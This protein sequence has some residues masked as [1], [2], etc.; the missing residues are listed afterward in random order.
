MASIYDY[1]N[2]RSYLRDHLDELKT[3]K[4]GLTQ[5]AIQM[6]MGISSSGFLANVIAGRCNL[7]LSQVGKI[8]KIIKLTRAE[9]VYFETLVLLNQAKT[10]EDQKEYFERLLALQKA[11]L[12]VLTGKQ[13]SLFSRWH[14]AVIREL[15]TIVP[16]YEPSKI[17]HLIDPPISAAEAEESVENLIALGLMR[18]EPDRRI[19]PCDSIVTS[20][21][22]VRSFDIVQFQAA[23]LDKAKKALTACPQ[24]QRDISVLTFTVS[25]EC[26]AQI[27]E[28]LRQVRK[29]ILGLVE[30]DDKPD[31]VYQCSIN[32]FPVTARKGKKQ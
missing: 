28:E 31:R 20:G 9:T 30:R 1:R 15:A 21:D 26:F 3:K 6:K 12:K 14:Y 8:A 4:S 18:R 27:K 23:A 7:T 25:D 24:E 32:L 2:Y 22:E 17:S 19:V 11:K 16:I 5:R 10:L 13:L 29:R